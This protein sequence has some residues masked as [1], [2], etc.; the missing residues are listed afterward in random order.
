MEHTTN[1]KDSG[2]L[3]TVQNWIDGN[4]YNP[5][6]ADSVAPPPE[7]CSGARGGPGCIPYFRGPS[8]CRP[9]GNCH[10]QFETIHPFADGN[11]RVGR[12][13]MHV[14]LRRRGLAPRY[15]PPS[16]SCSQ[17]IHATTSPGMPVTDTQ[18]IRIGGNRPGDVDQTVTL[19]M[20]GASQTS[21]T[22][23]EI[24]LR[25]G[26]TWGSAPETSVTASARAGC[27][28]KTSRLNNLE[29]ASPII[30]GYLQNLN[31]RRGNFPRRPTSSIK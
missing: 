10:A 25:G 4:D 26:G 9:S 1:P 12:A 24:G 20:H 13:L 27:G 15:V 11:G 3:R 14:V 29:H 17:L 8:T 16:A 30:Q 31:K 2:Q 21:S 22:S 18:G 7:F 23:K 5:C 28:G 19:D 6:G